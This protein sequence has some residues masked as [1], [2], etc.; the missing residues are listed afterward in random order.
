M[1][2]GDTAARTVTPVHAVGTR[3]AST[4]LDAERAFETAIAPLVPVL[5]RYFRRRVSLAD[6]AADCTSETLLALWRHRSRMPQLEDE[7][8][9]WAYGIARK[10]LAN[11]RRGRARRAIADD[12][13]RAAAAVPVPPVP[14]E[15]F[16]A[17]E[18]LKLLPPRDQELLRLIV[19]EQLSISGAG[20][21]LGIRPGTARARHHR[22]LARLR[23]LYTELT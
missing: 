18:A 14:D 12:A 8:R 3:S 5:V 2:L 11:H 6:D 16:I 1:S 15:A 13:L 22:A 17:A 21:V 10:V 7:R 4:A 20:R 23:D 9:A 19:W